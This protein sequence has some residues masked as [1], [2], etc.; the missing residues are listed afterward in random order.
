MNEDC[1]LEFTLDNSLVGKQKEDI[2]YLL[3]EL[4][5]NLTNIELEGIE[6]K[7]EGDEIITAEPFNPSD[8]RNIEIKFIK[9]FKEKIFKL[10]NERQLELQIIKEQL[11]LLF[12]ESIKYNQIL[13][14]ISLENVILDDSGELKYKM[15]KYNQ[16][17]PTDEQTDEQTDEPT[18]EQTD[19]QT[20]EVKG[21]IK[22]MYVSTITSIT[23]VP[24]NIKSIK[25]INSKYLLEYYDIQVITLKD[26][27]K[28]YDTYK[29]YLNELE[30][31]KK[32]ILHLIK[33]VFELYRNN[34]KHNNINLSSIILKKKENSY[35]PYIT[36]FYKNSTDE[37]S[38][39][40]IFK[41]KKINSDKKDIF[42]IVIVCYI[43]LNMPVPV[44]ESEFVSNLKIEIDNNLINPKISKRERQNRK[45]ILQELLEQDLVPD[46]IKDIENI[47]IYL[48]KYTMDI[49]NYNIK[50]KKVKKKKNPIRTLIKNDDNYELGHENIKDFYNT[51]IE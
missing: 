15:L 36:N 13:D 26:F 16:Q 17:E 24:N 1:E 39:I 3:I 49:N 45:I 41:D 8:S 5:K 18:D 43:I 23:C 14:F 7:N 22:E 33:I 32:I 28:N 47:L 12:K 19:E 9:F 30:L 42:C 46:E 29:E 35:Y 38:I 20:D 27:V 37:E 6:L 48:I 4:L 50:L 40:N 10:S 21:K 11:I 2:S 44:P 51:L 31:K 34:I 25:I